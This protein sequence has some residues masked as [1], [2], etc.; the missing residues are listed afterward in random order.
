MAFVM[1][2]TQQYPKNSSS[3]TETTPTISEKELTQLVYELII[4]TTRFLA[5]RESIRGVIQLSNTSD[6]FARDKESAK[7]CLQFTPH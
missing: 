4:K 7:N 2:A 3:T 5:L 1:L 6:I